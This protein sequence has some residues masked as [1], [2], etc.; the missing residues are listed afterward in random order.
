MHLFFFSGLFPLHVLLLSKSLQSRISP[1][2]SRCQRADDGKQRGW[3]MSLSASVFVSWCVLVF[4]S[5]SSQLR[6]EHICLQNEFSS[7]F[8]CIFS[9]SQPLW[10]FSLFSPHS[11]WH[12]LG[13]LTVLS[14]PPQ[15]LWVLTIYGFVSRRSTCPH[16]DIHQ[17]WMQCSANN[18]FDQ[19]HMDAF[20]ASCCC[21]A[22][23]ST[24]GD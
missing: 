2:S 12:F 4:P 11:R 3:T 16:L 8:I 6:T 21:C 10:L 7:L 15:P 9:L 20:T 24:V 17:I 13:L 23:V 22:V 18:Y 1:F 19:V 5:L 14:L